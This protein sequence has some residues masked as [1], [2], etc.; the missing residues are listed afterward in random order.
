MH[1]AGDCDAALQ[2]GNGHA[3]T[4][5]RTG[6]EGKM[7]VRLACDIE[8][9]RIRKLLRVAIRSPDTQCE[10]RAWLEHDIAHAAAP[11]YEPIP[12]LIRALETQAFLDR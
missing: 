10:I 5:V 6:G 9:I 1:R 11:G 3:R 4:G 7:A 2:P 12:E 8:P